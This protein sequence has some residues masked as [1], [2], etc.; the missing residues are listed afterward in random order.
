[1]YT[2]CPLLGAKGLEID[3][4]ALEL[5]DR[6]RLA[7]RLL[8]LHAALL[9]DEVAVP[10]DLD[11]LSAFG[12]VDDGFVLLPPVL[13]EDTDERVAGAL[14]VVEGDPVL[15]AGELP[16]PGHVRDEIRTD[17]GDEVAQ[18]LEACGHQPDRHH[19]QRRRHD[20]R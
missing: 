20:Q 8:P 5:D 7:V 19:G 3:R 12:E 13:D 14:P 16:L 1:L 9:E 18:L 6:G 2:T 11:R 4:V 10:S 17:P 15:E